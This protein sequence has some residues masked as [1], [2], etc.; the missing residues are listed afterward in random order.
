MIALPSLPYLQGSAEYLTHGYLVDVDACL[1]VDVLKEGF[2]S[3]YTN[4]VRIRDTFRLR[5]G[6]LVSANL[7]LHKVLVRS[8]G[9]I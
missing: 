1:V 4:C 8:H 9:K 7:V 3:K 2:F 5:Y 6:I